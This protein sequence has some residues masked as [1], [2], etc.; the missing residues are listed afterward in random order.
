VHLANGI[1]ASVSNKSKL[2]PGVELRRVRK[3]ESGPQAPAIYIPRRGVARKRGHCGSARSDPADEVVVRVGNNN[4]AAWANAQAEH[5]SKACCRADSI[6]APKSSG[7]ATRERRDGERGQ[8]N[9]AHSVVV[10]ISNEQPRFRP[11]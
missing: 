4:V 8:I 11:V 10:A 9:D 7:G 5:G 2:T 1:V 3:L 6:G